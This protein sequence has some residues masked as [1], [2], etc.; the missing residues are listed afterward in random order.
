M[1]NLFEGWRHFLLAEREKDAEVMPLLNKIKK[2]VRKDLRA[3][4]KGSKSEYA[5]VAGFLINNYL[6]DEKAPEE[7]CWVKFSNQKREIGGKYNAED[8]IA[9]IFWRSFTDKKPIKSQVVRDK[10][11]TKGMM[12]TERQ[13][14]FIAEV[15]FPQKEFLGAFFHEI[16]HLLDDME[17][18]EN[19]GKAVGVQDPSV[20]YEGYINSDIE[21]ESYFRSTAARFEERWKEGAENVYRRGRLDS[22]KF[23]IKK[24]L[25]EFPEHFWENLSDENKQRT[26][27]YFKSWILT[28]K[29]PF[30]KYK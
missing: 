15:L 16:G 25:K 21:L 13:A 29:S 11:N 6:S 24:F 28:N 26:Y 5:F 12:A 30:K 22:L 7:K 19:F 8:K 27:Q 18:I 1:E 4:A 23:L 14:A 17:Y 2:G 3:I 10:Y 20:D 9:T